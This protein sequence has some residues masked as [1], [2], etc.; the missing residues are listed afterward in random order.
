ML[1]KLNRKLQDFF[2]P[3][4]IAIGKWMWD[5]KE[6]TDRNVDM[7]K[8]KKILVLRYDGKI[9]DMVINTLM[10][11]ELKKAYPDVKIG[12]VTRGVNRQIIE[13][14]PHID[15]I[16]EYKKNTKNLK[17]LASYIA[18][19]N[20]D[21]LIDFS[22]MLRVKQ[23]MFINLCKAKQNLGINKIE[24]KLFDVS[25]EYHVKNKHIT[26]RYREVLKVLGIENPELNY[27]IYL[28]DD[29]E[30]FGKNF[31][32]NIKESCLVSFNPYG[33]SKYRTFNAE[34]IKE[35]AQKVLVDKK[36]A[37]AFI[38]PPDK[39]VEIEE[40][41]KD[42]SSDRLYINKNINSVLDSASI[43]KYSDLLISPDTSI[44]HIGVALNKEMIAVY[45]SDKGTGELNSVVWGPNSERARVI[46]SEPNFEEGEE[47]DINNFEF[48]L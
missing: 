45:R 25:V 34:K 5:R 27:E 23:M 47:A 30:N 13:N 42:L 36:N 8:V 18:E 3:K 37:I 39:L 44:V 17:K 6:N 26:D 19:E 28:T 33:A 35:I 38:F 4:R 41:S 31:R 11:R 43:I 22:E 46:Y 29:Q 14:N 10:F 16:Y 1:R 21:L 7:G 9:G 40:I 12:V 32:N 2:R 15:E 48:K 24:W 20:Y